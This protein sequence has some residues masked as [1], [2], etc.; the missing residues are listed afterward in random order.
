MKKGVTRL[1]NDCSVSECRRS[2][3]KETASIII[4]IKEIKSTTTVN[5]CRF[6]PHKE[7]FINITFNI[8][9]YNSLLQLFSILSMALHNVN[10]NRNKKI[11]T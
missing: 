5:A 1:A 10:I 9:N 7:K 2:P 3:N 11:V 4:A 8:C 6:F